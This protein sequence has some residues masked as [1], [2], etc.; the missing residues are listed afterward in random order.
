MKDVD[1]RRA[2]EEAGLAHSARERVRAPMF[3]APGS[4]FLATDKVQVKY[5]M[6]RA[7]AIE[8]VSA[9][10]AAA[11][12]GYSR[13]AFYLA[14]TAFERAGMVGLMDERAGRRG[15]LKLTPAIMEFLAAAPASTSGA[16]LARE[17][18]EQFG[19]ELHRRTVERARRR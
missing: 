12:H 17:V 16:D 5:E 6:L 9:T 18:T 2:I 13:A 10:S 1:R 8:G 7:H 14:V 11:T 19:V 4:F 15:P 3:T